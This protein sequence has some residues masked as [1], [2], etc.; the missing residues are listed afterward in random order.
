[1]LKGL[2][3]GDIARHQICQIELQAIG[4]GASHEQFR[5]LRDAQSASQAHDP[6]I[7]FCVYADPAIH[8]GLLQRN[9]GATPMAAIDAIPLSMRRP[10]PTVRD[11]LTA[12]GDRRPL[13]MSRRN[14]TPPT[15]CRE[16]AAHSTLRCGR[17]RDIQAI[18]PR[19]RAGLASLV[20]LF[21][22]RFGGSS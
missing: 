12:C 2:Y 6:P 4:T 9:T 11:L 1:L 19:N 10:V 20:R 17:R 7:D 22:R 5:D 18:S 15:A 21:Y 8:N 16:A 14:V 13:P 3:A